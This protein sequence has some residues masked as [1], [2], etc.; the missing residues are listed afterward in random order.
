[1][2]GFTYFNYLVDLG[3]KAQ[4]EIYQKSSVDLAMRDAFR[5]MRNFL[6]TTK[7]L[8]ENEAIS[9]MSVAV[10]F[11]ITQVVDGNW[12][13]H[14]TTRKKHL[15]QR[16]SRHPPTNRNRGAPSS[17]EFLHFQRTETAALSTLE[18]LGLWTS[19]RREPR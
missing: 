15:R 4:S 8:S 16:V 5:K 13:V 10:D 12:G 3:L 9:L 18:R 11:G 7:G 2:H 19:D 6:M 1:L 14:A 17:G